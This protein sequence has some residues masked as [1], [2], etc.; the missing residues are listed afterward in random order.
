MLT[1]LYLDRIAARTVE[2]GPPDSLHSGP[3]LPT[4]IEAVEEE[5]TVGG[6]VN[7]RLTCRVM[8]VGV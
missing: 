3:L 8:W 1:A 7:L 2:G 4:L 5:A 6:A